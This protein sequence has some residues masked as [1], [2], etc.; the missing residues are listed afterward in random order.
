M[1]VRWSNLSIEAEEQR[2][3]PGYRDEAVVRR[4]DAPEA[5]ETR[6][7]EVRARSVLNR[8]PEQSRMPFRWTINP[9]RGCSHACTYC[10]H[11][12]SAVLMADG[13]PRA[14]RELSV[15]DWIYGTERRGSCRRFVRTQVLDKWSSIKPAF[16]VTLQDRTE[17]IASGDHRFLTA[18]G[19][20]HVIGAECGPLQRPH[21]TCGSRMLGPGGCIAGPVIDDDYR[22]GYLCGMIRGDGHVE[23][24]S[25]ATRPPRGK[26][27]VH[28]FRLALADR[29]ALDRANTYLSHLGVMTDEFVFAKASGAHREVRAIRTQK[30]ANVEHIREVIG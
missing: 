20:K 19:W 4:F 24:Y 21:L 30:R 29:E 2:R 26:D 6:F 17:L 16:A 22:R 25:Y 1:F 14:M 12:D 13:R 11:G 7:Y 28:V 27:E 18:R 9:Y 15:G 5:L 3:L 23:S 10:I 8:V